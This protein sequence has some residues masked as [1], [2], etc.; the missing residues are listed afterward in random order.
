M[1][2]N[3][4]KRCREAAIMIADAITE[5]GA[6][7]DMIAQSAP[8]ITNIATKKVVDQTALIIDTFIRENNLSD[9]ERKTMLDVF[10]LHVK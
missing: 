3:D 1:S 4:T 2:K 8:E 5:I 10:L 6:K 7:L 9:A